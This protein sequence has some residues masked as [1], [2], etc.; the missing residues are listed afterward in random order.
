[1]SY[2][3]K[4]IYRHYKGGMYE[5][6]CLG[7]EE[8]TLK[9]VVIYKPLD[10]PMPGDIKG[11]PEGIECWTRPLDDFNHDVSI[12]DA[13]GIDMTCARFTFVSGT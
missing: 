9:P 7:V 5:M 10:G 4:G 13:R 12:P 6:I 2:R 1:M 3:G 8:A 11:M